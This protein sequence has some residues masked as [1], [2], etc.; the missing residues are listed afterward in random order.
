VSSLV[1][2]VASNTEWSDADCSSAFNNTSMGWWS[3][4][5][6]CCRCTA[7]ICELFVNLSDG[8]C[9]AVLLI[10]RII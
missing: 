9:V 1:C 10:L 3:V 6:C 5:T 8:H 7:N 2:V 4:E